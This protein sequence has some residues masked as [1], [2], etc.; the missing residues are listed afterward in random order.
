M[1][2]TL[3]DR[4]STEAKPW[5]VSE[6][7]SRIQ[8]A[9]EKG[10]PAEV[11][12]MG[13]VSEFSAKA[14]WYFKLKDQSA[15]LS[16][17]MWQ[18]DARRVATPPRVGEVIIARGRLGLWPAQGKLQLI[19]NSIKIAGAGTLEQQHQ[20]L[21]LELKAAGYFE[22]ARKLRLPVYPWRIAI[23][24][25]LAGA[26]VNDCIDTA[27]K[28]M[29]AVELLLVDIPVQGKGAAAEIAD[30]IRA[31]DRRAQELGVDLILVT[32]G[33]GSADDLWQ[34]NER[35]VADAVF[36]CNCPIASAI[37]HEHNTTIIDL[38]ADASFAT[39][40]QAMAH[41][42]PD[43]TALQEELLH[44]SQRLR[45]S[46]RRVVGTWLQQ[47]S[48]EARALRSA[49]GIALDRCRTTLLRTESRLERTRPTAQLAAR[50]A[51]LTAAIE[52]FQSAIR[53][54]MRDRLRVVDSSARSLEALGP[55]QVLKRG[56][57]MVR[58]SSGRL[59]RSCSQAQVGDKLITTLADGEF[60]S[61]LL[62]SKPLPV[63]DTE[64]H[65]RCIPEP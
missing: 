40:T 16:C 29:P 10:L 48:A 19:V 32:R 7:N 21:C 14:H 63:R 28:R 44:R 33:G 27:R 3:F 22:E 47:H 30:A 34:F 11:L 62:L 2:Q 37:G 20:A 52:R 58:D 53:G 46:V 25:S 26:A 51:R 64:P 12:V 17:T 45:Q 23:L 50:S 56:Y 13:E 61:E 39:P 59:I 15:A 55:M 5:T 24:T 6:T 60:T 35:A 41:I 38:V 57:A 1:E 65:H 43:A 9:M 49:G 4:D 42:L 36:A 54:L 18:S 8:S 31:V